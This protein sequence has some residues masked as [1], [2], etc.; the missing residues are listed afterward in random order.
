VNVL[1]LVY[2]ECSDLVSQVY[3]FELIGGCSIYAS[4]GV[5]SVLS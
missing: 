1:E 2:F 4:S 3:L 5:I